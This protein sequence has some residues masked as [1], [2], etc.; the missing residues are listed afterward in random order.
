M[1]APVIVA[2]PELFIVNDPEVAML[3]ALRDPVLTVNAPAAVTALLKV[4]ELGV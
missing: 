3:V 4:T 1:I 2:N